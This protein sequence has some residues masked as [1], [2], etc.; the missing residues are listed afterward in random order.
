MKTTTQNLKFMGGLTSIKN[1][2]SDTPKAGKLTYLRSQ[3]F[4]QASIDLH[5]DV[6]LSDKTG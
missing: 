6:A 2:R 1:K 4:I 5:G 3:E